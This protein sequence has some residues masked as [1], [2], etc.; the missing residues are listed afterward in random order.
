MQINKGKI[1]GNKWRK[2]KGKINAVIVA[3]MGQR[4]SFDLPRNK[5]SSL[6]RKI[7]RISSVIFVL[8]YWKE[9]MMGFLYDELFLYDG[10][11]CVTK[12]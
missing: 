5:S 2:N 7:N 3:R 9:V 6:C 8:M 11:W 10:Y 12:I 4:I 1:N